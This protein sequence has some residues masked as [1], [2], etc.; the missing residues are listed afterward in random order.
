MPRD[1]VVILTDS[2]ATNRVAN[3]EQ[4][5][6]VRPLL[7]LFQY[8]HGKYRADEEEEWKLTVRVFNQQQPDAISCGYYMLAALWIDKFMTPARGRNNKCIYMKEIGI[9]HNDVAQLS[10]TMV[11]R[12]IAPVS[13]YGIGCVPEERR[14]QYDPKL[15]DVEMTDDYVAR[16]SSLLTCA[17]P[18]TV[19]ELFL[20]FDE[21]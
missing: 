3:D 15:Y 5:E 21:K 12:D 2:N 6:I 17:N 13:I 7:R 19:N 9:V 20:P 11:D 10:W 18:L 4:I 8:Y 14:K 16:V 1:L